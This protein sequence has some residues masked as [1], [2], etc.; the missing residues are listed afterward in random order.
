MPARSRRA[1]RAARRGLGLTGRRCAQ[2]KQ[3]IYTFH[4][5]YGLHT[6]RAKPIAAFSDFVEPQFPCVPGQ[7]AAVYLP[8]PVLL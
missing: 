8:C 2:G 7:P 5:Y 4:E 3:E 6:L 1:K